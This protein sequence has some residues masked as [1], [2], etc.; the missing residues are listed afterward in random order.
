[1]FAAVANVAP[2][3]WGTFNGG[4]F[5]G[6]MVCGGVAE[7]GTN[8]GSV[9]SFDYFLSV[10]SWFGVDPCEGTHDC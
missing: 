9:C 5:V 1:M 8:D 3:S 2:K 4:G 10:G 6:S 7:L